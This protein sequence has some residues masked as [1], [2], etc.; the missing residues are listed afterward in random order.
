APQDSFTSPIYESSRDGTPFGSPKLAAAHNVQQS[1][2]P[3]SNCKEATET[4]TLASAE[5]DAALPS[6]CGPTHSQQPPDWVPMILEAIPFSVAVLS[7]DGKKVL[8]HTCGSE[9]GAAQLLTQ[10]LHMSS[11]S[12]SQDTNTRSFLAALLGDLEGQALRTVHGERSCWKGSVSV[13]FAAGEPPLCSSASGGAHP[14][15]SCP[16][17]PAPSAPAPSAS[18][19]HHAKNGQPAGTELGCKALSSPAELSYALISG[20]EATTSTAGPAVHAGTAATAATA[21]TKAAAKPMSIGGTSEANLMISDHSWKLPPQFW[22]DPGHAMADQLESTYVESKT[23]KSF[24]ESKAAKK[25]IRW[26]SCQ[27]VPDSSVLGARRAVPGTGPD[28]ASQ[29]R[30]IR[31]LRPCSSVLASSPRRNASRQSLLM[32]ENSVELC[33]GT[34]ESRTKSLLKS[35]AQ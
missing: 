8:Y 10:A 29:P 5:E 11:S 1:N 23:A 24:S 21:A 25:S 28:K 30:E 2:L 27:Q 7:S 19:A 16:M 33:I 34:D 6:Q 31:P 14:T 17:D 9:P 13:E 22:D 12:S 3:S 26:S 18:T 32:S 35:L 4:A 15:S 20:R